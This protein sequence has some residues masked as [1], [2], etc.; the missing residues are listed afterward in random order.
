MTFSYVKY[1]FPI[2]PPPVPSQG[3]K[4]LFAGSCL[5]STL[6]MAIQEWPRPRIG[7]PAALSQPHLPH[8][9][10]SSSPKLWALMAVFQLAPDEQKCLPL[11][12]VL[13][14]E[15]LNLKEYNKDAALFNETYL[16]L[17][18]AAPPDGCSAT[19]QQPSSRTTSYFSP[20]PQNKKS[21][22]SPSVHL[23]RLAFIY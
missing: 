18:I 23:E 16:S 6:P 22:Y 11:P 8:I 10:P 19:S 5:V 3:S 15:K 13:G 2:P 12:S 17:P 14:A 7:A 4:V 9:L 21:L 20:N 1:H